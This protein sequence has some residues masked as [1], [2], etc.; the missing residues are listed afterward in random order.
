MPLLAVAEISRPYLVSSAEQAD[1][2]L[3]ANPNDRFSHDVAHVY[4]CV[5]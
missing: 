1:L 3:V 2:R 4:N 5:P